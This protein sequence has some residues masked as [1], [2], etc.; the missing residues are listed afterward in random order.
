MGSFGMVYFACPE[1]GEKDIKIQSKSG[2]C[3][4]STWDSSSVPVN[5][6]VGLPKMIF[7]PTCSTKWIIEGAE[8]NYVELTLK[9]G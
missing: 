8:H 6:V 9:R 2:D 7:C 5:V 1:C 4:M 3:N